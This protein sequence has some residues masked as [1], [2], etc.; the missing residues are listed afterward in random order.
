ALSAAG[1]VG[2][3]AVDV[4]ITFDPAV[5]SAA[6]A[7][8]GTLTA[9]WALSANLNTPGRAILSL[10]NA[11]SVTGGGSL[12]LLRFNIVKPPPASSALTIQSLSLNDGAMTAIRSDGALTVNGFFALGGTVHYFGG[13]QAV[14]GVSLALAGAGVFQ[15]SSDTNGGF[16]ITNIPTGSYTLTPTKTNQV[17]EITGYDAALVLQAAAGLLALSPSQVVA[18]DVNRNGTVSAMDASYILE[19]AVGLIEGSFPGAGRLWDFTPTSRSYSLLNSDQTG[20]DFTAVLLGDVS[21]NWTPPADSGGALLSP[22][23]KRSGGATAKDIGESPGSVLVGTDNG[24][25]AGAVG[26]RSARVLLKA[27]DASVYSIDLILSYAPTNR[28]VAEVRRGGLAGGMALA[29]NTNQSGV[30]RASLASAAPLSGSGALLV[31]SFAGSDPVAWQIDQ[32]RINESQVSTVLDP[33]LAAFDTDGDGLMDVDEIEIFHT[34]IYRR[35]TDGDG[36]TD[37]AEVRAGTDPLQK[38]DVFAVVRADTTSGFARVEWTAKANRT[39]QIMNSFDLQ[40]WTNA[41]NGLPPDQQSL[42]TALTNGMLNYVDPANIT[43]GAGKTY[44]RVRLVE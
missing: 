43:S 18:A 26:D 29:A 42:Q 27:T 8:V 15:T 23:I 17:A 10:A 38:A 12:V 19:K 2:L 16:S 44:Y 39:Y 35:D 3:R 9:G 40:S 5:L 28:T 37:G 31:V 22:A 24:P 36:M 34:D 4:T 11:S 13:S 6:S 41:P 33:T 1:V 25:L 32:A 14:P 21:G 30:V 7:R 20:Q